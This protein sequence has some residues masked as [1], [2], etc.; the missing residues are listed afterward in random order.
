VGTSAQGNSAPTRASERAPRPSWST[1]GSPEVSGYGA[2][3]PP[4]SAAHA[5]TQLV[6]SRTGPIG[7]HGSRITFASPRWGATTIRTISCWT[8]R[9]VIS[10]SRGQS[11]AS[12]LPGW[13]PGQPNHA[14]QYS[15]PAAA[16]RASGLQQCVAHHL[17][18]CWRTT[19]ASRFAGSLQIHVRSQGRGCRPGGGPFGSSF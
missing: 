1:T 5:Y 2:T 11:W 10:C 16:W 14:R 13:M 15:I 8:L 19:T 6:R 7:R 17:S 18:A 12:C 3:V 4:W 9:G